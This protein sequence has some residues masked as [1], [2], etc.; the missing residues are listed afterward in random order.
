MNANKNEKLYSSSIFASWTIS[1]MKKKFHSYI[2]ARW[3]TR[4]RTC[5]P[6]VLGWFLI[7][8]LS[9]PDKRKNSNK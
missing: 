5:S 3:C 2:T 9:N 1:F 7:R 8:I 6:G 4:T